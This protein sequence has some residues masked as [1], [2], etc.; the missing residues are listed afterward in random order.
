MFYKACI[1]YRTRHNLT[2]FHK[3]NTG[4]QLYVWIVRSEVAA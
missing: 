1:Q 3:R 4:E 2:E